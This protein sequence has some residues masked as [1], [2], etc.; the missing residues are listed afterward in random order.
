MEIRKI[1]LSDLFSQLG[2][3]FELVA[4]HPGRFALASIYSVLVPLVLMTLVIGGGYLFAR[5]DETQAAALLKA[6]QEQQPEILIYIYLYIV[7]VYLALV[8]LF[9][10]WLI[11]CRQ[12]DSGISA[13]AVTPFSLYTSRTAW[14][15]LVPYFIVGTLFYIAFI[16]LFELLMLVFGIDMQAASRS[17]DPNAGG[18]PM[19]ALTLGSSYWTA[20]CLSAILGFFLQAMLYLGFAQCALTESSLSGSLKAGVAGVLKNLLP[21]FSFALL[22]IIA[23]VLVTLF[24]I[25][26][27]VVLNIIHEGMTTVLGGLIMLLLLLFGY[28]IGFAFLYYV[29]NGILGDARQ[30]E[31]RELPA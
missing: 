4:G 28:P 16:Y 20:V 15:K 24:G 22:I 11:L 29:W 21:I 13:S 3:S 5:F 27:V 31:D 18:D 25:L 2:S 23:L 26:A 9:A 1:G 7:L 6:L 17:M 19:A 30:S 8:P 12:T 10:G 14:I